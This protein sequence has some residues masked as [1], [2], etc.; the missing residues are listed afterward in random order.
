MLRRAEMHQDQPEHYKIIRLKKKGTCFHQVAGTPLTELTG[1]Q[2]HYSGV[3][4]QRW[5]IMSAG[6]NRALVQTDNSYEQDPQ[7]CKTVKAAQKQ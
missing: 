5:G 3:S 7:K 4:S 2:G 6:L 1:H